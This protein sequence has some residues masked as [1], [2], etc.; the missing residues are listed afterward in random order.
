LRIHN[1]SL[2]NGANPGQLYRCADLDAVVITLLKQGLFF[3]H[4]N[5]YLLFTI[6]AERQQRE[7]SPKDTR[8]ALSA[9]CAQILATY[10]EK[11][12]ENAPAGQ[13][14]LPEALKLLPCYVNC[15]MKHDAL[16][17]GM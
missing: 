4:S 11:C 12:S 1:L 8:D 16:T 17:G 14:I 15:I 7:K 6:T 2:A 3:E 13:L 9:R 5:I 10:R